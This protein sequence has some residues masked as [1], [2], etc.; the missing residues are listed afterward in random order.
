MTLIPAQ[1]IA[2]IV[3]YVIVLLAVTPLLGSYMARVYEGEHGA[4]R[5]LV[6]RSRSAASTACCGHRP[7]RSRTGRATARA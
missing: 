1:G 6:R 2:Q 7:T 3:F 5:P 4:A